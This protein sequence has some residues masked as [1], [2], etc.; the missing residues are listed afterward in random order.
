LFEGIIPQEAFNFLLI[1]F[2]LY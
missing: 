2:I 1:L